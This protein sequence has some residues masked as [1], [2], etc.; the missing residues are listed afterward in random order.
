[1]PP[2]GHKRLLDVEYGM[3]GQRL[4]ELAY[5]AVLTSVSSFLRSSPKKSGG[6]DRPLVE[7]AA[8]GGLAELI[9]L[10]TVR[11]GSPTLFGTGLSLFPQIPCSSFKFR[12]FLSLSIL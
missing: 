7:V 1:M 6:D 3:A 2:G 10:T 11:F 9:S 5:I 4:G 8:M 12:R